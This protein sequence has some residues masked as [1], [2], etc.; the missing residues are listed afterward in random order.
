LPAAAAAVSRT[1]N[2][3]DWVTETNLLRFCNG[4]F[5]YFRISF[6]LLINLGDSWSLSRSDHSTRAATMLEIV[7]ACV[8]FRGIIAAR[9][10]WGGTNTRVQDFRTV[11][12]GSRNPKAHFETNGCGGWDGR[13]CI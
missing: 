12:G 2:S 11:S 1:W 13:S 5:I 7:G 9:S 8:E 6:R 10:T 3:I 4:Y